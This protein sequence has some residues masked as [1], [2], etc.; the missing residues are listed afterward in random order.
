MEKKLQPCRGVEMENFCILFICCSNETFFLFLSSLCFV[1]RILDMI[2]IAW[3]QLS[4]GLKYKIFLSFKS[5][6]KVMKMS[7]NSTI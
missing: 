6:I 2:Y 4:S 3:K 1:Y 7:I 5:I